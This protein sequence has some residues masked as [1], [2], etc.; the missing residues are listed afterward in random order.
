MLDDS[1][2]QQLVSP[3]RQQTE[4][5]VSILPLILEMMFLRRIIQCLPWSRTGNLSL[6]VMDGQ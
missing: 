5:A 3:R 4:M 1:V 6:T 2:M